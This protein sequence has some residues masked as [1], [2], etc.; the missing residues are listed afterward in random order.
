[1]PLRVY[2]GA[3]LDWAAERRVEIISAR[4]LLVP[5][6]LVRLAASQF[7][8]AAAVLARAFRDDPLMAYTIPNPVERARMLPEIYVRMVRFGLLTGEVYATAGAIEGVAVWL[9]PNAR[10]TRKN[11]EASGMHQLAVLVGDDA[12]RRYRAVVE[13]E[14]QARQR[15]MVTPCWYLFLLGVEPR[16]QRH[17]LGSELM[18]PI[19]ERAD[20]DR[21]ACYL[22]TENP[23]N[24]PF[25]LKQG[26]EVILDGEEAGSS[27]V[28]FWTFRRTPKR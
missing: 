9:P 18:R 7:A 24:V 16:S 15:D 11:I 10:W 28:K 2:A 19:L 3:L 20:R 4:H 26:F 23:R 8:P 13:C 21:L 6:E 22:E 17:G 14:W 1:M 27:D 12:Y 25:Y 5:R